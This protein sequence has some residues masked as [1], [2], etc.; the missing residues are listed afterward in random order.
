MRD[1]HDLRRILAPRRL[2]E[3][4]D[5]GANPLEDEAPYLAMLRAG[6]C[7]VTGFE[8]QPEAWRRL[9]QAAGDL[10]RYLPHAVGDGREHTLHVC[11]W[12]GFSSIFEPDPAQLAL[13]TDFPRMAQVVE[14]LPVTTTRLDDVPDLG[15]VDHLK[16]DVQGAEL[17]IF[18]AAR[19]TL[20]ATTSLQV[21]VGF[22]RLYR[23]QPTFAEV[24]LELRGQGFVPQG[25]VTTKTWPLAP[26]E[27]ADPDEGRARQ[28]VEAD[29]LY[30]R[31][32]TRLD[33]LDDEQLR[34]LALVA[35]E[36][37]DQVG[38]ARIATDELRRRGAVTA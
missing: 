26:H 19:E 27:W 5:I 13:L 30:V 36:V 24:D 4:V 9:Q 15:V 18:Q 28:L 35:A 25:F 33:L 20:A 17:M 37:Y 1:T 34:H 29:V 6:R 22:H 8:P 7:R 14:R 32:L 11:A 2:T 3:V 31:D 23:G 16:I 38:V 21:E 12:S 10:E